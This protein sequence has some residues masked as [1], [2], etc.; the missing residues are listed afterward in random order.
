V[1]ITRGTLMVRLGK[2]SKDRFIPLGARAC[3]WV[4]RYLDE[5]R[6]ALLGVD[7]D[8]LFLTD[9]GEP[10]EKGR[11]SELAARYLRAGGI[12]H[13]AC[14]AL[15]HAM[16]THMLEGGADTQASHA[17][18]CARYMQRV[19]MLN[20]RQG[21]SPPRGLPGRPPGS[22]PGEWAALAGP[23]G[24]HASSLGTN[25]GARMLRPG[26]RRTGVNGRCHST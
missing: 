7:S 21:H 25:P 6:P 10:F 26:D 13:G 3:A 20:R 2:G 1:D 14:H 22:M 4:A 19:V 12:A 24:A 9:Y 11:L 16:A 17:R 23:R 8:V 18:D 15:R 5:V